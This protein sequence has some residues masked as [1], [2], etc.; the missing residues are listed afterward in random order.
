MKVSG[1]EMLTAL[2]TK[3]EML[4]E[5]TGQLASLEVN[6]HMMVWVGD[7]PPTSSLN[8]NRNVTCEKLS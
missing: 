7:L 6:E 4:G 3:N 1:S 2:F 8:L 5:L